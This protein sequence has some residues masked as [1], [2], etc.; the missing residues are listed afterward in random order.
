MGK[1]C[2]YLAKDG[3]FFKGIVYC[4]LKDA[5]LKRLHIQLYDI[6]ERQNYRQKKICGC[7]GWGVREGMGR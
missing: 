7:Q 4:Q 3:I 5:S 6:S 2:G 1:K